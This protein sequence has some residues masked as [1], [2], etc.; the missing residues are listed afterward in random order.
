MNFSC[1]HVGSVGW[2]SIATEG[3]WTDEP[4]CISGCSSFHHKRVPSFPGKVAIRG[5]WRP[6]GPCVAMGRWGSFGLTL[7]H[8]GSFFFFLKLLY[9]VFLDLAFTCIYWMSSYSLQVTRFLLKSR[10]VSRCHAESL[11]VFGMLVF[12]ETLQNFFLH[13]S[14]IW[15]LRCIPCMPGMPFF[16]KQSLCIGIWRLDG[17]VS[18]SIS[19]W[20]DW[21]DERCWVLAK[22]KSE[23]GCDMMW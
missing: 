21:L 20:R 10:A 1:C 17:P 2:R 22:N 3:P 23:K 14:N 19:I 12:L 18:L 15:W 5:W 6:Y 4:T 11:A 8:P 13:L 9:V 7:A 16:L